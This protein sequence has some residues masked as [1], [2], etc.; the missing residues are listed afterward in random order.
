MEWNLIQ[1]SH[2]DGISNYIFSISLQQ[3][4]LQWWIVVNHQQDQ[5]FNV[6][7][8]NFA[9]KLWLEHLWFNQL[10]LHVFLIVASRVDS[11]VAMGSNT[12]APLLLFE[13]S[14]PIPQ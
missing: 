12:D 1:L 11:E 4:Y 3:Y 13:A 6:D 9:H 7:M 10:W 14:L 2:L 8:D 5:V